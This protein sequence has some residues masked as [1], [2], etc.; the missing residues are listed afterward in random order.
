V[1]LGLLGIH[2]ARNVLL[3]LLSGIAWS[4]S[5][6]C[7]QSVGLYCIRTSHVHVCSALAN[8][9]KV[10]LQNPGSIFGLLFRSGHRAHQDNDACRMRCKGSN[11]LYGREHAVLR[12]GTAHHSTASGY[13][14]KLVTASD[15]SRCSNLLQQQQQQVQA[16]P[17]S[18]M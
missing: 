15:M 4:R 1:R 16:L 11:E 18:R 10:D 12:Q 7:S 17:R 14:E 2:V 6:F 9:E 5:T 13:T 3:L 8:K